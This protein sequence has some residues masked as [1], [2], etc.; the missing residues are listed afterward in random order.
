MSVPKG[1]RSETKF[2]AQH[3]FYK[4]RDEVTMLM[5]RRFGFDTERYE[6][7]IARIRELRKNDPDP[8]KSVA[9]YREK[10][11][12]FNAWFVSK[13]SDAVLEILR[14][15]ETNFTIG[16]SIHPVY[17]EE[18]LERR[19]RMDAAIGNCFAL[20][21]E[22]QYIIRTLPVDMNKFVH[23]SDAIDEQIRLYRGVRQADNRFLKTINGRPLNVANS[24]NFANCNANGNANNNNASN[25]NGVRPDFISTDDKTAVSG[26]GADLKGRAVPPDA[27]SGKC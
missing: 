6:K 14:N 18:Y 10:C 4:L 25:S 2:E 13:E 23:Y 3:H 17:Y 11:D 22:M 15:I 1:R 8:E 19:S 12:A 26:N 5:V 21:Q 16:N 27:E 7:Q 24:T 20:K 9:K